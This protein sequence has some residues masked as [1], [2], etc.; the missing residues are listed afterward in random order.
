MVTLMPL[1]PMANEKYPDQDY[2]TPLKAVKGYD[3]YTVIL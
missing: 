3:S 2:L 1:C